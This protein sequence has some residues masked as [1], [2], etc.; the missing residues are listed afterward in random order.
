[1]TKLNDN[2]YALLKLLIAYLKQEEDSQV[3]QW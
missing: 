1:V 3:R 2:S